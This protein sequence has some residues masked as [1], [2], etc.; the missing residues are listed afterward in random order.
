MDD[1]DNSDSQKF[2]AGDLLKHN[3]VSQMFKALDD[4]CKKQETLSDNSYETSFTK[5]VDLVSAFLWK[6]TPDELKDIMGEMRKSLKE[7]F[8]KIDD[9]SLSENNKLLNKQKVAYNYYVE[10]FKVLSV[11]LTN[12]PISSEFVDMEIKGDFKDLIEKVR[13]PN[14]VKLF[15]EVE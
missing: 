12:S 13:Q 8:N 7:E 6:Y 10:I 2:K 9:S 1:D 11:V 4:A 5:R 14:R 15:E 3:T